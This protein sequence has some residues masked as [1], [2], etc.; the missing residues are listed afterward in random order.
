MSLFYG[1]PFQKPL[2]SSLHHGRFTAPP[3]ASLTICHLA[4]WRDQRDAVPFFL[5][6][7]WRFIHVHSSIAFTKWIFTFISFFPQLIYACIAHIHKSIRYDYD[8]SEETTRTSEEYQ[9][10]IELEAEMGWW[11]FLTIFY[12]FLFFMTFQFSGYRYGVLS[13]S[14]SASMWCRGILICRQHSPGN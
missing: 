12:I 3:S 4:E 2:F 11:H 9:Q 6:R 14:L 13:P 5:L 7:W 10:K 8:S 1:N